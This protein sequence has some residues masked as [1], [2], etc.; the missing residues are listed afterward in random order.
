[1]Y[2][3]FRNRDR[4][5]Y[6]TV[7]PPYEVKFKNTSKLSATGNS[8]TLWTYTSNPG[9]AEY[10]TLM[11]NLPG[12][13]NKRLPLQAQSP[14][15]QS[16]NVIP[17]VPHFT[18]YPYALGNAPTKVSVPQIVSQ[19]GFFL[20]KYYNRLAQD[21]SGACTNDCPIFRMGEV[22]LNDA[23]ASFELGSFNQSVADATINKL[24]VRVN[25]APMVVADING[26]FDLNRDPAVDPVLWEIRRE[27]RV[28]LIGDGLRFNDLKRWAKGT[29]LNNYPLGAKVYNATYGNKLSIAGGSAFG[30]VQYFPAATGWNDMYYLE[31]IPLQELV[32]NPQLT[33][34]PGWPSK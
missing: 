21:N 13:T 6:F 34:N 29:Y 10:V 2:N 1:M 30:Y 23:E 32:V 8:D 3:E 17:N 12:N 18:V 22:L 28:E 19:L 11:N 26:S 15:M 14:D 31:P 24:R 9:D 25:V 4:R 5:L 33:Q 7:I 27:R 16:G 20:W